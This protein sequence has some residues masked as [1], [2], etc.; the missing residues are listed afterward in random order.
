MTVEYNFGLN[1]DSV[2]ED[3]TVQ[4]VIDKF[5]SRSRVGMKRYGV[6]LQD[7][8]ASPLYWVNAAQEEAMD[9]ILYLE[10]LKQDLKE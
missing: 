6:T 8:K 7:N 10:R 4:A 5:K 2:I 9:F 1:S 3:P